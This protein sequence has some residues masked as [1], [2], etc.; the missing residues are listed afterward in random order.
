MGSFPTAEGKL[1][2]EAAGMIADLQK[3][4]PESIPTPDVCSNA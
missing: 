2:F 3:I 4:L 1:L